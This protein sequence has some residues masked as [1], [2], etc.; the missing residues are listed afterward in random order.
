MEILGGFR[1][2]TMKRKMSRVLRQRV[3]NAD[4]F[5]VAC[6]AFWKTSRQRECEGCN[7]C[8]CW[9]RNWEQA[10]NQTLCSVKVVIDTLGEVLS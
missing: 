1:V 10:T 6:G 7:G 9:I 5:R 8:F 4:Y 3:A 2:F